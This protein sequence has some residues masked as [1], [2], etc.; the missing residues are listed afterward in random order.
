MFKKAGCST[1]SNYKNTELKFKY[2]ILLLQSNATD[3]LQNE[4]VLYTSYISF[5][6]KLLIF[7]LSYHYFF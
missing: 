5:I 1:S 2:L 6:K 4:S 3:T 7:Y